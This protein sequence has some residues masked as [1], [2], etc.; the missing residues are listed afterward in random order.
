LP[1][2]VNPSQINTSLTSGTVQLA[3]ITTASPSSPTIKF[4]QND[5][6]VRSSAYFPTAV[7]AGQTGADSVKFDMINFT[8]TVSKT[9]S[10]A[11]PFGT[12]TVPSVIAVPP[13]TIAFI[14]R[15]FPTGET[16]V[17]NDGVLLKG[18][19]YEIG[20]VALIIASSGA[21]VHSATMKLNGQTISPTQAPSAAPGSVLS[22]IVP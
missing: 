21:V 14:R 22:F 16:T 15:K 5:L 19:T 18:A 6:T 1:L 13:P 10:V 2:A 3:S 17:V 20:G 8:D 7:S 4:G 9:L 12:V 11:T